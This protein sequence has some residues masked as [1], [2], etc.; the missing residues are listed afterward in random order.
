[1]ELL[2]YGVCQVVNLFSVFRPQGAAYFPEIAAKVVAKYQF[3]KPPSLDDLMKDTIKFQMGRFND[4]LI[5][6]FG[7]YSD[8]IIVNGKCPT[9]VLTAFMDDILAFSQEE[10]K[11]KRILPERAELHFESTI[12]VKAEADLAA[13]IVPAAAEL[14]RKTVQDKTSVAFQS[15]GLVMDCDTAT[16][17]MRR[18]PARFFVERRVGFKFEENIFLCIAP[19]QTKD[20]L[21][22]LDALEQ[23][24]LRAAKK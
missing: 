3:A 11:F 23:E 16:L 17:Q 13:F 10:L 5:A 22:L 7:I 9:E 8:G 20:H 21:Q 2:D 1:M 24:A 19:L 12:V 14:I 15:S 18:K 4:V 6:E